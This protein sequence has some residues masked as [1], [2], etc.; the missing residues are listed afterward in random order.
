[1]VFTAIKGTRFLATPK[2]SQENLHPKVSGQGWDF[3]LA[4]LLYIC[5]IKQTEKE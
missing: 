4:G 3:C 1:V 2:A 5:I